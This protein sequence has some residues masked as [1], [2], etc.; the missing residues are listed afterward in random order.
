MK[1]ESNKR[2][3]FTDDFSPANVADLQAQGYTLRKASAYHESDTLEACAEVAGDVPQAYLDLIARTKANIIT[4]NVQVGITPELQKVID[5][6]KTECEKVVAENVE[7]KE[8]IETLKADL[9][10]GEPADLSGLIPA[11][12]FDAVAQKLT[13]TEDQLNKER[14]AVK[15]LTA[16]KDALLTQVKDLESKLKKQ[17]AAEAKAAKAAEAKTEQPKE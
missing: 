16:E 7:L 12:Q 10:P 13:E 1:Q 6:A 2:L 4:A 17:T 5:D 3:Y 15:K 9:T 8:Q 11:E 14:E